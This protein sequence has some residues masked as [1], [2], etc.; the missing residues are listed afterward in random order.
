[1]SSPWFTFGIIRE[2]WRLASVPVPFEFAPNV[3]LQQLPDWVRQPSSYDPLRAE[4]IEALDDEQWCIGVDYQADALGTPDP[5]WK[6]AG[7]R[8]LQ[9]AA[10]SDIHCVVLSLWLAKRVCIGG[11]IIVDANASGV[12]WGT[13]R[14][15]THD[16]M[17]TMPAYQQ[18]EFEVADLERAKALY[19]AIDGLPDECNIHTALASTER[20]L[21]EVTFAL[22]HILL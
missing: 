11:D 7:Q 9:T 17:L 10:A 14:M 5:N 15:G 22:R 21:T 18:S 8:D 3:R 12:E 20:A 1:M 13:R 16:R 4:V 19:I 2:R 6:G